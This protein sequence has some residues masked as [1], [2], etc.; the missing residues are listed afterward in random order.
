YRATD[1]QVV[2]VE[3][4]ID[5]I[6]YERSH[7]NQ[8]ACYIYTGDNPSGDSKRKIAH[9]LADLPDGMKVVVALGR[10]RRG[11]ELASQLT[12]LA[13][14]LQMQRQKPQLG[15]RWADQMQMEHRHRRS[16]Q[17]RGQLER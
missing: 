17:R 13:A 12:K 15:S 16:L 5:A 1:R 6:A 8:Q 9:L 2:L 3:R 7:G 4:P 14:A 11:D 10:D